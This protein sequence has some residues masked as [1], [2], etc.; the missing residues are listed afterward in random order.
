MP[1]PILLLRARLANGDKSSEL[2]TVRIGGA[3]EQ[4]AI[5]DIQTVAL[6]ATP[7]DRNGFTAGSLIR[8]GASKVESVAVQI[9]SNG[10]PY[11]LSGF[12]RSGSQIE[13]ALT[14]CGK[15]E[16]SISAPADAPYRQ[17]SVKKN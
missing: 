4:L 14:K 13:I 9:R 6:T 16:F 12:T 2:L 11:R 5:A 15:I 7:V 10:S 1:D 8:R 17:G 3:T